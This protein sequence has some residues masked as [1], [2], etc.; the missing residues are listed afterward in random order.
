MAAYSAGLRP[1][2]SVAF[3]GTILLALGGNEGRGGGGRSTVMVI[4]SLQRSLLQPQEIRTFVLL[5]SA[6]LITREHFC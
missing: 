4:L 5:Y 2:V 1:T 3:A 6:S